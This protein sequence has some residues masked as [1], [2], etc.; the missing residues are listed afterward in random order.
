M[1]FP[2]KIL[3][4]I[5]VLVPK[6]VCPTKELSPLVTYL[7]TL[8]MPI[9]VQITLGGSVVELVGGWWGWYPKSFSCPTQHRLG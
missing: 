3:I 8:A 1:S 7:L 6:N 5:R 4:P 9:S 2:K